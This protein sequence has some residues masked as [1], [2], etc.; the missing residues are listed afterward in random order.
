M[1]QSIATLQEVLGFREGI[2]RLDRMIIE[3]KGS[4]LRK[5]IKE[6]KAGCAGIYLIRG[7]DAYTL[8]KG[9]V[10]IENSNL[11]GRIFDIDVMDHNTERM[12]REMVGEKKRRCFL[13]EQDAKICG[14]SRAHSVETLQKKQWR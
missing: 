8:K 5:E 13:C 9:A 1:K 4:I 7:I 12:T 10:Y 14:R 6:T 3:Y 2:Y 11:L